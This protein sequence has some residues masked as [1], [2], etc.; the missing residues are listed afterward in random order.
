M[1]PNSD[2]HQPY[3]DPR[4]AGIVLAAQLEHFKGRRDVVVLALPRRGV[5][6]AREV[7]RARLMFG[8]MCSSFE[9]SECPVDASWLWGRSRRMVFAF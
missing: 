4:H 2:R 3:H 9:S 1:T 8:S 5:P 6:V 7:A